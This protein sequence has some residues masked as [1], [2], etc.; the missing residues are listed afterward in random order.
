MSKK[1]KKV[2]VE[3]GKDFFKISN[4]DLVRIANSTSFMNIMKEKSLSAKWAFKLSVLAKEIQPIL[5]SVDEVR[6]L[7]IDK[8]GEKDEEGKVKKEGIISLI[9]NK[10]DF[11]V[12]FQDL[13][14][15]EVS[16][17]NAP[18]EIPIEK[19]PSGILSG[20]DMFTLIPLIKFIE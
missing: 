16:L 19:F 14:D 3:E 15:Q 2:K 9:E 5:T 20:E 18:I 1:E 17:K 8:Y 10:T 13:M 6:N 4:G 11:A 7:L 12:E